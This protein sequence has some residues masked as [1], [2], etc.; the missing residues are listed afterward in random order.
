MKKENK[1]PEQE[2]KEEHFEISIFPFIKVRLGRM[3][4][5]HIIVIIAAL[6]FIWKMFR[7]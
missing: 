3:N 7:S 6:V 4:F 5:K 2:P 1:P